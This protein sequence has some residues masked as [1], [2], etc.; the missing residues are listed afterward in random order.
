MLNAVKKS[1][2]DTE[3]QFKIIKHAEHHSNRVVAIIIGVAM[4]IHVHVH[5]C[6][7]SVRHVCIWNSKL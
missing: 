3:L 6:F 5:V 2:F 7:S 4:Y 1:S